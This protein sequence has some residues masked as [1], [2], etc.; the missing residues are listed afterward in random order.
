V[1]PTS[2]A[3]WLI[4]VALVALDAIGLARY[5]IHVTPESLLRVLWAFA[6]AALL[7]GFYTHL[8]P[9]RRIADLAHSAAVLIAFFAAAAVVS[10]VAT[11]TD[12]PLADAEFA[13]A[14]RALGFDWP[15]WL[16]WVEA[17]PALKFVF[18]IAYLSATPQLIGI[19]IYV[20]LAGETGRSSDYVWTIMLSL[21]V[22]VPISM[23]WP[24]GGAW[25]QYGLTE[26]ANLAQIR[27]FMALRGGTMREL[28]LAQLEGLINFPSFH[29]TLGVLF[30]YA[31]RGRG[32]LCT[33][34]VA[35]N[36]V[37]ILS[38]LSEG[39]HYL[40]DVISGAAIAA[41]AISAT[42]RLESALANRGEQMPEM[43]ALG[44]TVVET[45]VARAGRD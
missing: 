43:S 19:A 7:G 20:A 23:L 33:A 24:A 22:I 3:K 13:A 35:L 11:V 29:A 26:G 37:M 34:S 31:L 30:M 5:A 4:V 1:S 9:S 41:V 42:A 16:A 27:D 18:H 6:F 2:R 38:V 32:W 44:A 28:D 40:V 39:G 17:R 14:D 25:V 12:R 8:R 10:Y 15:A 45:R 36:V 21:L